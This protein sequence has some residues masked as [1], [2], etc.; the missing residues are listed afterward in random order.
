MLDFVLFVGDGRAVSKVSFHYY[1]I[2]F[3]GTGKISITA[4]F[5]YPIADRDWVPLHFIF[6]GSFGCEEPHWNFA[7]LLSRRGKE[8]YCL[9]IFLFLG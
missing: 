2:P 6:R 3:N 9:K 8:A 5:C 4:S 1:N 7:G